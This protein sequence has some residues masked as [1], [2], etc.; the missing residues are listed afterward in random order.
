[1]TGSV[2]GRRTFLKKG[3]AAAAGGF[4]FPAIV[5]SRAL[6]S[7]APSQQITLG[8]IGV[9]SHGT[10]MNLKSFLYQKDARILS[11]CDVYENQRTEAKKLVGV[12]S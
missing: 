5:P 7:Q 9:G 6:G 1:M 8:L 11:V 2:E 3:L 10:H 12:A 4:L